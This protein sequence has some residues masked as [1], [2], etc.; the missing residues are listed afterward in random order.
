[1]EDVDVHLTL[2]KQLFL[3]FNVILFGT[4]NGVALFPTLE[5]LEI[6]VLDNREK[7]VFIFMCVAY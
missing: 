7:F 4:W 2:D 6:D 1:M 3:K 5:I